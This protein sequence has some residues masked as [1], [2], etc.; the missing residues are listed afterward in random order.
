MGPKA[1][2]RLA[3]S[4]GIV[5]WHPTVKDLPL[6]E[7]PRERLI[8]R[9]AG[10]LST[11]ELLAIILRGGAPGLPV[12]RLA[13]QLIA[14]Y[15]GLSGLSR[16]AISALCE[17]RGM[18]EAKATQLK[19]ALELGR[20]YQIEQPEERLQ[21]R[22]PADVAGLL[23]QEMAALEQEQFRVLLLDTKNRVLAVRTLYDGTVNSSTIRVGEVFRE[24]V[25]Q[26]APAIV[27]V[28]NHPSGDPAPSPEDVRVTEAIIQGGKTLDIELLDHVIIGQH[29][30]ASLKEKGLAF[31]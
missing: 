6:Q 18:G 28:H 19:A 27:V 4:D 16:I 13:E 31:R 15:H 8:Q 26:N 20:R 14:R 12:T 3:V 5:E 30:F 24:A 1:R 25:R 11:T 2:S 29:R 10:S 7:R 17:E 22:S 21:V 9:G 23:M